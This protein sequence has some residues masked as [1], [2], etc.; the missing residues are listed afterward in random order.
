MRLITYLGK[1]PQGGVNSNSL[2]TS[3][4]ARANN[5][6]DYTNRSTADLDGIEAHLRNCKLSL[7]RIAQMYGVPLE[8]VEQIEKRLW[9]TDPVHRLNRALAP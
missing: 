8:L 3:R 1:T 5:R 6:S 2:S 7:K 9:E 4:R